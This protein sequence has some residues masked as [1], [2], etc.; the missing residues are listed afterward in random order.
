M[1]FIIAF[2]FSVFVFFAQCQE[3]PKGSNMIIAKGVSFKTTVDK[4]FDL[5]FFIDRQDSTIGTII[6]TAK[7]FENGVWYFILQIRIKDS[8]AYISGQVKYL[9]TISGLPPEYGPVINKGMKGSAYRVAFGKMDELAKSL[10]KDVS[11][12]KQ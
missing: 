2:L 8:V 9:I 1:K 11:Y 6:T 7:E 5:G 12:K 3:A 10:S 4:V